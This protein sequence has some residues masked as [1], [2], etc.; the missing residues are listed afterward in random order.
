MYKIECIRDQAWYVKYFN[1]ALENN[2]KF[3]SDPTLNN[4]Y[5]VVQPYLKNENIKTR[6]EGNH[7]NLFCNDL[8]LVTE[9]SQKLKTWVKSITGPTTQDEI[10]FLKEHGNKKVLCKKLPHSRY[11]YKIFLKSGSMNPES[12]SNFHKWSLSH[13]EKIKF[14]PSVERWLCG[15][16]SWSGTNPFFYVE[17]EKLL[18][19]IGLYL[20]NHIK[21]IQEYVC[22]DM[23]VE[24]IN[25]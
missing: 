21:Q 14:T 16:Q 13:N 20:G 7:F 15:R 11:R 3:H 1:H 6:V 17:N 8:A 18:A 10:D 9:I 12:R 4:F 2:I 19:M 5:E 23:V 24:N 22:T 25:I